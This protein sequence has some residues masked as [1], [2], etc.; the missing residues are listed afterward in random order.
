MSALILAAYGALA[1]L[2]A[3]PLELASPAD[4]A[5]PDGFPLMVRD[6]AGGELA[7]LELQVKGG[8]A[9]P[10]GQLGS[11][12]LFR[13]VPDPA[14]GSVEVLA[15]AGDREARRAFA[16]GPRGGKVAIKLE[17][18]APV[19]GQDQEA[20]LT[21]EVTDASGAP[22][23]QS[24]P[25]I[26]RAN[27]GTLEGLERIGPGQYRA[28]YLL[29]D[30][31]YPEVAVIAAFAAWP[32]A[33][34]VHG[35]FGALRVPLPTA[36][37]LPGRAEANAETT[38]TIAGRRFGP[39]KT[40]GQGNFSVPVVVPPG[41]GRGTA[42]TVDRLG[43]K[44]TSQLDLALPP[45][46]QLACVVN[47]GQLPADGQSR[48]RVVCA[49]SDVYGNAATGA[50]V[51][52]SASRGK[53]TAPR[54][55]EGGVVEWLYVAPEA[56]GADVT[57]QALWQQGGNSSREAWGLAL[58]QGPPVALEASLSEPF[59]HLGFG[60]DLRATLVDALGRKRGG[61]T[62]EL[63]SGPGTLGP[64]SEPAAGQ[65]EARWRATSGVPEPATLGVR[66]FGPAG[67]V[68]AQLLAFAEG[69][70]LFAAAVDPAGLPVPG[71]RLRFDQRE[72][73][74]GPNGCVELG[75]AADGEHLLE[76]A[77]W[78]GLAARVAV[79]EGGKIVF[80]RGARPAS[81]VAS[82][83]V[84]L[85]PPTPVDVKVKVQGA[86]VEARVESPDGQVLAGRALAIAAS[87]GRIADRKETGGR[88]TF[89]VEGAVGKS[90]VTVV[91]VATRVAAVV[92]V[93]L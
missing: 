4:L 3:A 64:S 27:V 23:A 29:P 48:A 15:R 6:A 72:V 50:Q 54:A 40:D 85:G 93:S 63:A 37:E 12:R 87:A 77:Q 61:A 34:S 53:L 1:A 33:A 71:Q 19:K 36:I 67:A 5:S 17:P 52:L 30:T 32:H 81:Q 83:A 60:A 8:V 66:A 14:A 57:F 26:V 91:D 43:N 16:V 38:V 82:V 20:A 39:V 18:A 25:P 79:R 88:V 46:D 13:V 70:R 47:P 21:V 41:Y 65:L 24:A 75:A 7:G 68:P 90:T 84:V 45:T 44:R 56:L 92:E 51:K 2:G 62:L 42:V 86:A 76:H 89:R 74:T 11:A 10:E 49:T 55:R 31:R 69:G 58:L 80:P 28:R 73:T 22:D 35:T 59:V 78:P 9:L